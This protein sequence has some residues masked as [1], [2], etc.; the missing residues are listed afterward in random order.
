MTNP[1]RT[2][3]LLLVSD[4]TVAGLAPHLE[5]NQAMPLS[6]SAAPF[7]QVMS[8]LLDGS[9]DCWRTD[10]DVAFVWTRPQAAIR[11]F[12]RLMNHERV[13]VSEVLEDVDR[14]CEA[15]KAAASRV[16]LLLVADWT[17]PP[18]E[19][20]LGV[21]NMHPE[22][23]IGYALARMNIRLA[24][25]LATERNV[26]ILEA[27]KWLARGGEH[28]VSPKLWHLGKIAF[29]PDVLRYAAEDIRAA[30]SAMRGQTRKLIVL[31]LDE[32]LWGG[33]VGDVGW[34]NLRLGGHDAIGEALVAFQHRLKRLTRRG[35]VLAIV[36][37]NTEEIAIEAIDE[38]PEMVLRRNDFVAWK[39]NWEDK[40]KNISDLAAEIGLG[41]DSFVFIDDNP[42]ERARVRGAL[43]QVLV[44]DWPS[45]KLLYDKALAE[46][47]C[48]DALTLSEEDQSRTRMYV[49]ERERSEARQSAQ[50]MDEYLAA[51]GLVVN[52][53][54]LGTDN[55]ARATQLLNKTNQMN[56]TTRRLTESQFL[57][58]SNA[59]G[60]HTLVFRVSDRFDNYGLTGI[61]SLDI[62][63]GGARLVD[64]ILSCRVMG[65]GV[66]E[67]MLAAVIECAREAGASTLVVP[68]IPT[69]KNGPCKLFFSE[70][71]R[72]KPG[73]DSSTFSWSVAQDYQAP[74]HVTVETK[75]RVFS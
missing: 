18:F 51:M 22:F 75:F 69:A 57:D 45:D 44:P 52:V 9:L 26:R 39:I 70:R 48:F 71:S 36:S 62:N 12:A 7:D 6:A 35:V 53:D 17:L 74:S 73:S 27:S 60:R 24:E 40:A 58:W 72:L 68:Y 28:A 55:L 3:R 23:G 31:D 21:L 65:R 38:H 66:E 47:T 59:A 16:A 56:L 50:S 25:A 37:K 41:L 5:S 13:A 30:V 63:E 42:A 34:Q 15:L 43:P 19:R 4:F 14:F 20:G 64:Y 10:P 49:A 61:A 33:V 32:T 29:G 1:A 11:S 67:T 2:P 8:V 46:L 54:R